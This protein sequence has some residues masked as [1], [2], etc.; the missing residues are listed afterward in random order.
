M[1]FGL[2]QQRSSVAFDMT[3]G[4]EVSFDVENA[5][6]IL[7]I[8]SNISMNMAEF[9]LPEFLTH[10]N[11]SKWVSL[12]ANEG[13]AVTG[14]TSCGAVFIANKDFSRVAAGHMSGDARFVK[15]WC[16]KLSNSNSNVQ[17]HFILW[18]T[19]PTGSRKTGGKVLM[20]YMRYFGISPSRAPAVASCGAIF[21]V[22]SQRGVAYA[23]NTIAIPFKR[24]GQAVREFKMPTQEES[25]VRDYFNLETF[26]SQS[27]PDQLMLIQAI[28]RLVNHEN[29]PLA[30]DEESQKKLIS[31]HGK[32]VTKAYLELVPV[33]LKSR[34]LQ[35]E[36]FKLY[37]DWK[38]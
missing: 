13:V 19:G 5:S 9:G 26:N 36:I 20:E 23:S 37:P 24:R 17:P 27:L 1:S 2:S 4:A 34:F 33:L 8:H 32:V 14:L 6:C 15:D 16:N 22:R 31:L 29:I 35:F 28:A 10:G 12:D 3:T 38:H 7:D 11:F 21:L 25:A 30:F 18:G